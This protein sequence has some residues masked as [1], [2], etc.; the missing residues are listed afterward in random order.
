MEKLLNI[1][2][3]WPISPERVITEQ[4]LQ[5]VLN[6]NSNDWIIDKVDATKWD[7]SMKNKEHDGIMIS[8]NY[9]IN[10]TAKPR[11]TQETKDFVAV[12]NEVIQSK[13]YP[14]REYPTNNDELMGVIKLADLHIDKLDLK[15]T[16]IKKKIKMYNNAIEDIL[17][18]YDKM[19]V[20]KIAVVNLGDYFNT[21][22]NN[23]TTKGTQQQGNA[24]EIDARHAGIEFIMDTL[25]KGQE[26]APMEYLTTP[27]NHDEYKSAY[28][29]TVILKALEQHPNIHVRPQAN[30]REYIKRGNSLIGFTHWHTIK[31][32]QVPEAMLRD[33]KQNWIKNRYFE[34]WHRHQLLIENHQWVEVTTNPAAG[35]MNAR[36]DSLL[37]D[38][39]NY[40]IACDVYNKTHG[41][42]FTKYQPVR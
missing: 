1:Q 36:S 8:E 28:L 11:V 26:V 40:K 15:S 23:A 39:M 10:I 35:G 30:L 31:S 37:V 22:V 38:K 21:D 19:W 14:V 33:A 18:D 29:H 4:Q 24:S 32:K 34:M 13:E 20:D 41:K 9:R 3:S 5:E 42:I 25:L 16:P 6:L 27:W 2:V 17:E 7:T 12:A